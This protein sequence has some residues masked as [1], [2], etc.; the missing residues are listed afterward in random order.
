VR[1]E[2]FLHPSQPALESTQ[3][4]VKWMP[5]LFPGGNEAVEWR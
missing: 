3:P 1:G 2:I 4:P 5:G